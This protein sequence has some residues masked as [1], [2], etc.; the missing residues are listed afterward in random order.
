[1]AAPLTLRARDINVT[2]VDDKDDPRITAFVSWQLML[3]SD[4]RPIIVDFR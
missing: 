2:A 3:P 1:M 4:A